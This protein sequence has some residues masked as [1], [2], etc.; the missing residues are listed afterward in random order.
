MQYQKKVKSRHFFV[1]KEDVASLAGLIDV[2]T[3]LCK[4]VIWLLEL[5][6]KLEFS[7]TFGCITYVDVYAA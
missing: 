1:W 3:Y 4:V 6:G 5:H 7:D 2:S